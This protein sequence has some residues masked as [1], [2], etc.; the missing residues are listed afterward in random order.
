VRVEDL[1]HRGRELRRPCRQQLALAERW[2]GTRWSI[3]PIINPPGA[4]SAALNGVDCT[5]P[6]ACTA[7]GTILTPQSVYDSLVER[8][9]GTGWAIQP[10]PNRRGARTNQLF[11]VD[12]GSKSSCTAVGNFAGSSG[13]FMTLAER[14]A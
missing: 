5:L 10:T 11:G 2:D 7:V 4:T 14:F 6:N 1:L 9:D 12:C 3:Q 8:W 13:A